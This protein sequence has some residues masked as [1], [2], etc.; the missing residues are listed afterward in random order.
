MSSWFPLPRLR[1]VAFAVAASVLLAGCAAVGSDPTLSPAQNQLRQS[2]ARFNQTVGEGALA[3]ALLGGVAGL[4]LGGRNRGRAALIG[5][6]AG[7]ALGSGAGYLAA[8]NN[9]GRASTEAQYNDAIEQAA[10][11]ADAYRSSA[12]AS[13][14]IAD[15]AYADASRLGEQYRARQISRDQYL[16][17]LAKYQADNEIISQQVA[18]SQ[19][20]AAAMRQD[21][22]GA[23]GSKGARLAETAA[24]VEASRRQLEQSQARLSRVLAGDA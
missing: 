1:A 16:S 10:A 17:G 19:Q 11:D 9:L 4:A 20:A 3:G 21:S 5:A 14:Q 8:R 15:Q 22:R 12:S 24:D 2:D 6:T 23:S 13:R 18:A 7:G